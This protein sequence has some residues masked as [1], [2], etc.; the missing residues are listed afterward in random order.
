[1]RRVPQEEF[2]E[3]VRENIDEFGM[4]RWEAIKEALEQ[5]ELSG[6]D[7]SHVDTN[8]TPGFE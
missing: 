6:A 5:F 4:D 3:V 1:M 2:D 8:A 7:A